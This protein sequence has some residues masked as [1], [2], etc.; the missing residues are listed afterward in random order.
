LSYRRRAML[1]NVG[2]DTG[3]SE[4]VE[5]VEVAVG[6]T[7]PYLSVQRVFPLLVLWPIF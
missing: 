1:A 7:L 6:I 4:M 5:I 2:S 3:R